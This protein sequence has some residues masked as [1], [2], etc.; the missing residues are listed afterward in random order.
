[1]ANLW[2]LFWVVNNLIFSV[3]DLGE[4]KFIWKFN[5]STINLENIRI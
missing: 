2:T 4:T 3:L 1:M 5:L